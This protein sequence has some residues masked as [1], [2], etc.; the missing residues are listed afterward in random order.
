MAVHGAKQAGARARQSAVSAGDPVLAAKITAPGVPG[1]AVSRP[2]ITELIGQ[3]I[4]SCRL[5]VV[6]GPP[7]AGKTTALALWAAPEP[8]AVAW[9]GLDRYDNRPEAFWSYVV[10]A[11]RRA[12]VAVPEALRAAA[13]GRAA[14]HVFLVR[15]ASALAAQNP[16][17]TLVLDDLHLLTDPQVLDGLDFVLRYAG[18]GLRL[19]Q[20]RRSP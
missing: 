18:P 12:D 13:R 11:L 15:L 14:D 2:R 4:R 19:V 8:G 9:V 6:T 20:L 17:V 10:A 3:G 16:P 1:W 5:T 7:G